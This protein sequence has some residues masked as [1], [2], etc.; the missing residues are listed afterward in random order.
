MKTSMTI[1][2][3]GCQRCQQNH[4]A[5]KFQRLANPTNDIHWWAMCPVT[6]QPMYLRVVQDKFLAPP[7]GKQ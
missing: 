4:R 5:V 7:E 6:K 1:D 3:T 2:I